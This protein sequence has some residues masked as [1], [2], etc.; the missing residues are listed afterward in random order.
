MVVVD[1]SA[2]AAVAFDDEQAAAVAA[3]IAG[4][5]LHAPSLVGLEL[6]NATLNR[7]KR[8]PAFAEQYMAGFRRVLELP[9]VMH[10]VEPLAAFALATETGLSACDASYLWLSHRLGAPLVSADKKLVAAARTYR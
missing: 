7:C 4:E 10:T 3:Q 1:A 9:I 5:A 8:S 2:L 6:A